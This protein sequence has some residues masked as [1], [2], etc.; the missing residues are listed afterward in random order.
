MAPSGA[1]MPGVIASNECAPSPTEK[2]ATSTWIAAATK[3]VMPKTT[4]ALHAI[5]RLVAHAFDFRQRM[6]SRPPQ[7]LLRGRFPN[8][9]ILLWDLMIGFE[10]AKLEAHKGIGST[11]TVISSPLRLGRASHHDRLA[12]AM[13][14][15]P[16]G[17]ACISRG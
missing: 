17:A 2:I 9:A 14:A 15:N 5:G 6:R 12:S 16:Y 11:I 10:I 7:L 4:S 8:G 13:S 1:R 3:Y